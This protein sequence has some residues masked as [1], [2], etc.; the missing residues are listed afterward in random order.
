MIQQSE[1]G[2][3][4]LLSR[5]HSHILEKS[6]NLES[7]LHVATPWPRGVE[8]LLRLGGET[9]ETVID[10][11]NAFGESPLDYAL[12]L[13]KLSSVQLLINANAEI[14]LETTPSIETTRMKNWNLPQS[15]EVIEFLCQTLAD[16]R[17]RMLWLALEWLPDY[18]ISRL[19]LEGQ[20][21]LQE[22]AFEVSEA[23]HQSR[24]SVPWFRNV[25]PGSIYHSACLS[26]NVA[27]ALFKVGFES[28]NTIFHGFTPL[29]TVDL[30]YLTYRRY[31]QGTVDLVTWFLDQGADLHSYIPV[32]G[33]KG[34][35]EQSTSCFS[36]FKAIHR[37]ADAYG[38]GLYRF[39]ITAEDHLRVIHMR[40]IINDASTD[41]C[42]CYCS[43]T[44]CNPATILMRSLLHR[45]AHNEETRLLGTHDVLHKGLGLM[46]LLLSSLEDR[47]AVV[48]V[49]VIRVS[50]FQ[51]LGMKHTCCKYIGPDL[52]AQRTGVSHAILAGG[53]KIV[54]IMDIEEV[55]EI[56]EEDQHLALRLEALVAEFTVKY[57]EQK[58]PFHD[59]FFGYWWQRMDEVEAEQDEA[60]IDNLGNIKEIGVVLDGRQ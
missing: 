34:T 60:C 28:P 23:L 56:Q 52:E 58:V 3:R 47:G 9:I 22:T 49:D 48:A 50:T 8:L 15:D 12:R 7:P 29:M 11:P 1:S 30:Y 14:D 45:D 51:R 17:K 10:A 53:Y 13:S 18:E 2:I 37:I 31:L 16:R 35:V 4:R 41:P 26:L 25:R 19:E 32:S 44:G 5:S 40:G 55:A 6:R 38:E 21:M 59:F 36:K 33:L 43:H 54:D 27:Q 24:H 39:H 42:R 20:S 57:T 46:S